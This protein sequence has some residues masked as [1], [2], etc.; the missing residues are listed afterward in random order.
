MSIRVTT[1][2]YHAGDRSAVVALAPRL[3]AGVADWRPRAGVEEAVRGWVRGSLDGAGGQEAVFVAE[4][5]RLLVGMVA[6]SEQE[7]W[8]GQQDAYVG[9][10]VTAE[11]MEG[12]G[13]GRALLARAEAWA[14]DQGLCRVTLETGAANLRARRFYAGLGYGEEEVRLTRVLD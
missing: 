1:R 4:V 8:S 10:L 12:N 6:V 13:V 2:S 9:E 11:D 3:V 5:G 7:H 14:R